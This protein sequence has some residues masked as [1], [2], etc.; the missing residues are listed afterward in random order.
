MSVY[1]GSEGKCRCAGPLMGFALHMT[2]DKGLGEA[3]ARTNAAKINIEPSLFGPHLQW[4]CK[5][6]GFQELRA[7]VH[8]V[9]RSNMNA[10]REGWRASCIQAARTETVHQQK[11]CK[12]HED[13]HNGLMASFSTVLNLCMRGG[14]AFPREVSGT[15]FF[16]P[17][18]AFMASAR[19]FNMF[20]C[21]LQIGIN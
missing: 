6:H 10:T 15:I 21:M 2:W 8:D 12:G 16:F 5:D 18:N 7:L 20:H 14:S 17:S 1:F 4:I 13:Q 19:S 11:L 3:T 9:S